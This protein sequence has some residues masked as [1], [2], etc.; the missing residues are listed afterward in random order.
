MGRKDSTTSTLAQNSNPIS[1]VA[2]MIRAHELW[3]A[4]GRPPGDG[5]PFWL[6]AER[7]LREEADQS[8]RQVDKTRGPVRA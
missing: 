2:I 7:E 8:Q 4:A 6:K 5:G 3:V 1:P